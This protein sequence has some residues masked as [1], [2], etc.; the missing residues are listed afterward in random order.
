MKIVN[1]T[2]TMI[3]EPIYHYW[4]T[5]KISTAYLYTYLLFWKAES[6]KTLDKTA[7]SKFGCHKIVF[8]SVAWKI[9]QK[10]ME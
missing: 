2:V 4:A 6:A 10:K 7:F 9:V 5:E 1:L 8:M 3:I